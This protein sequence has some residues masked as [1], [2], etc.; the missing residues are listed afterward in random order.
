MLLAV[1]VSNLACQSNCH[2]SLETIQLHWR[3]DR[4]NCQGNIYCRVVLK[5]YDAFNHCHLFRANF[6][7]CCKI[8]QQRR[9]VQEYDHWFSEKQPR[10]CIRPLIEDNKMIL[11]FFVSLR[12]WT[13]CEGSLTIDPL[14]H[15]PQFS[16]CDI[17][18]SWLKTCPL[19]WLISASS[20]GRMLVRRSLL[21]HQLFH[22]EW[23]PQS[24]RANLWVCHAAH[25]G[26]DVFVQ[27]P[28]HHCV[29]QETHEVAH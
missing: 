24:D 12:I 28:Y 5:F 26:R 7:D 6:Y 14:F 15:G 20:L 19:F 23:T 29:K 27:H 8:L 17:R 21:L 13:H 11:S 22:V 18:E 2:L 16:L 1:T 4:A 10:H 9:R 25:L 3:T